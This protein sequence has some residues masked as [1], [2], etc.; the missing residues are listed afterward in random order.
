[1]VTLSEELD[2]GE[3]TTLFA[4]LDDR[5]EYMRKFAPVVLRT[6]QFDSPRANNPI[7]EGI[8]TL[9]ELNDQGKKTVPEEAPV[10]FIP[11]KWEAAVVKDEEVNKHAW[12]F[13]LLHEARDALRAGDLT[14]E[15]SQ[16]YAAWDSDLY[17]RDVWPTRRDAWYNEQA[18]PR[19]ANLFLSTILDQLHH[20]TLHTTKRM[21][22][23]KNQDARIEDGKLVLTPLEK[24]ELAPE[25]LAAHTD[26]VSVSPPTGLPEVLLEVHRWTNFGH[27]LTH[28][29]GRRQ[30]S[31]A[32]DA[33]ILPALLAVLVAE[34]T[35][36]GLAT[37]AN[38]SGI[39]LHELESA[40]DWYFREETLRTT[41]PANWPFVREPSFASCRLLLFMGEKPHI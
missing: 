7:L 2:K 33:A 24:I 39:A 18:L 3:V 34:A 35:N 26:L 22:N 11:K 37:M 5:Y 29:T 23:R 12:E 10:T 30:P 28:L 17:Q 6:L 36:L 41:I 16:R 8:T 9:S 31:A 14:V 40:Y 19:D 21:A 38:S 27:D 32:H 25:I 13:A 15:G 1:M 20:Q 4:L